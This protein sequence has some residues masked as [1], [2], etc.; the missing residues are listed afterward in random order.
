[1]NPERR[2]SVLYVRVDWKTLKQYAIQDLTRERLGLLYSI[3]DYNG[4]NDAGHYEISN[5]NS[6]WVIRCTNSGCLE[7]SKPRLWNRDLAAK[8]PPPRLSPDR[9]QVLVTTAWSFHA[10]DL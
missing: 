9:S 10:V 1:M 3:M 8:N 2:P 7:Q 4:K 6:Y 5:H